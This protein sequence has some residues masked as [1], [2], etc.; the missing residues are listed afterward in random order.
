MR[1]HCYQALKAR[2]VKAWANGPGTV[3]KESHER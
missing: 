1:E 3:D 2:N